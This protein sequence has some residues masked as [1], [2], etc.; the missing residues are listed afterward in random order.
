[1]K[2][3]VFLWAA[4]LSMTITLAPA[5]VLAQSEDTGVTGAGAG[6]FGGG[7]AF[8]GIPL[9]GLELGKGVSV[10]SDGTATGEFHTV[11]LGTSLLGQPQ[12]IDV[13]GKVSSGSVGPDGSATFSGSATVDMGDGS[14]P[15]PGVPFTVTATTQSLLL[16]LGTSTLPSA[17]LTAGSIVIE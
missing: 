3:L 10:A 7:A 13:D 8:N 16:T 5:P 14:A 12:E 2:K 1:M 11:L 17:T 15:L 9:N 6:M 4:I